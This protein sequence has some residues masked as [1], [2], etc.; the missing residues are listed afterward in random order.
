MRA[1]WLIARESWK[2]ED[3]LVAGPWF[4]RK[5]KKAAR[6]RFTELSP[7]YSTLTMVKET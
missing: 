1:Y 2:P 6:Q 4:G 3:Q 7:K 5:G